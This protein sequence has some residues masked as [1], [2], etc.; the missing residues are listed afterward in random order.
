LEDDRFLTREN[1]KI[2]SGELDGLIAEWTAKYMDYE[3]MNILQNAGIAAF[4]SLN[5]KQLHSDPHLKNRGI[6]PRVEHPVLGSVDI[7]GVPW[8]IDGRREASG[9]APLMGEHN[10]YVFHT[11][12]GLDNTDIEQL[13]KEEII[14]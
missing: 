12:L 14:F 10:Y 8:M 1:R 3:V 13:E 7:I 4:P 5:S 11:L 2:N 6:L 9:R